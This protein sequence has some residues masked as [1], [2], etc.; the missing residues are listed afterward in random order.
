M[1]TSGL[2]N[3][4]KLPEIKVLWRAKLWQVKWLLLQN[5]MVETQS[6]KAAEMWS[7]LAVSDCTGKKKK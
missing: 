6:V 1:L 7:G 5:L 4:L 3:H 2:L